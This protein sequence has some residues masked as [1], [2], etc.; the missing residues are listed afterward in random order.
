LF[1]NMF[2]V[3]SNNKKTTSLNG[4]IFLGLVSL[5]LNSLMDFDWNLFPVYQMTM[6]F[7]A[8]V[9]WDYPNK[10][11]KVKKVVEKSLQLFFKYAW[12]FL[13][14][15]IVILETIN[16]ITKILIISNNDSLAFKIFPYFYSQSGQFLTEDNL[17]EDQ[18][19]FLYK[20]YKNHRK[21]ILDEIENSQELERKKELYEQ[22]TAVIPWE[23][24]NIEYYKILK[25]LDDYKTLG[26]VSHEGLNLLF[27]LEKDGFS[28][29][30]EVKKEI[31]SYL[32][33]AANEH[34]KH[35]EFE[36]SV[37]YYKDIL[38]VQKWIFHV[39]P[40]VFLEAEGL[41]PTRVDKFLKDINVDIEDFGKNKADME[42]WYLENF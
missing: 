42:V 13:T 32:F 39:D 9:L 20:L 7:I 37:D 38:I 31:M 19:K 16:S 33:W 6:I 34:I 29:D 41:D 30:Y 1:R 4:F 24:T 5:L 10:Y 15:V 23:L 40:P 11:L 25:E 36:V 3:V 27:D 8:I 22:L 12:F 18:K 21:F 28:Q 17:L 14:A 2:G 35:G 26:E